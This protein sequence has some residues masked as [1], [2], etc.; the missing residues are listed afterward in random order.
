M[1]EAREALGDLDVVGDKHIDLAGMVA[2]RVGEHQ[3]VQL[4]R[5][6]VDSPSGIQQEDELLG[7]ADNFLA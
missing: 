1:G 3:E 4:G 6:E 2:C 7:E 5:P